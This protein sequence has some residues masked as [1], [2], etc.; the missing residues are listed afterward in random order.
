MRGSTRCWAKINLSLR[1][2]AREDA[3]YH[4]IETLF[5]LLSLTDRLDIQVREPGIR[6]V[7]KGADLG[8]VEDNLVYRAAVDFF[9][10]AKVEPAADILLEKH[11]PSGAG[12]GG[13]SSD[14]ASTLNLLNGLFGEPLSDAALFRI[15]AGLGSDIPFFL[16][17]AALALGWGRGHR[18]LALPPLREL[19][20]LLMV[21]PF[22]I[23]TAAAYAELSKHRGPSGTLPAGKPLVLEQLAS[24]DGVEA[25]AGNDFEETTFKRF[26]TL[27]HARDAISQSGARIAMLAGSGSTVF[28][29]YGR[30]DHRDQAIRELKSRFPDFMV[31]PAH[32]LAHVPSP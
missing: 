26:P 9:A 21:P 6:L 12:L 3:G 14:A 15:G 19:P 8:A 20:L 22:T 25:I 28:G 4:Q 18:L 27:G 16:S 17:G 1:I 10:A 24:W 32:T 30:P 11:I 23:S 31:L 7:V 13:G 2:L 29:V 5:C